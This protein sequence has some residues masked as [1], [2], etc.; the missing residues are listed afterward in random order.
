MSQFHRSEF[1]QDRPRITYAVQR[2]ILANAL[3][4]AGQLVVNIGLGGAILHPAMDLTVPGGALVDWLAFSWPS[5]LRGAVWMPLTY[6]FIHGGL[7]HLFLNMLWLFIFGPDVER[8]LG[9]RQFFRFYVACGALGV[10]ATIIPA[11]VF[12]RPGLVVGASG[13][14]MG[15]VVAFTLHN[16][17]REFYLFPLPIPINARGLLILIIVFNLMAGLTSS[18]VSVSTHFG[19]MIAGY[20]YMK[21]IPALRRFQAGRRIAKPPKDRSGD[22]DDGGSDPVGKAVDNLFRLDEERRRR[23]R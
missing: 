16:P 20:A 2:L 12:G 19:G 10:L 13:A 18:G 15:V 22:D 6:M 1:V 8:L 17:D 3:V 9:T 5:V 14:V 7:L 21:A 23:R 4:F 11:A